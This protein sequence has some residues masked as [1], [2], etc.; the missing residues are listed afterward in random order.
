MKNLENRINILADKKNNGTITMED[1]VL[2]V[3]LY[4]LFEKIVL[5]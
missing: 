4:D 5:G 1:E 3:K 2:L